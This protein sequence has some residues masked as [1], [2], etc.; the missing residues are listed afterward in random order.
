[1]SLSSPE[2]L[3]V[4]GVLTLFEHFKVHFL[5]L[6]HHIRIAVFTLLSHRAGGFYEGQCSLYAWKTLAHKN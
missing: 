2:M 6:A 4:Q 5:H 3:V 1:M